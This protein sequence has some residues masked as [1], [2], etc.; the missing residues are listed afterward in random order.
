MLMKSVVVWVLHISYGT[1]GHA[2]KG[3][4]LKLSLC[5]VGR[6]M[7]GLEVLLHLFLILALDGDEWV[8]FIA[9]LGIFLAAPAGN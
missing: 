5:T 2:G 4:K 6:R 7:G 3:E 9:G 8:D 1:V